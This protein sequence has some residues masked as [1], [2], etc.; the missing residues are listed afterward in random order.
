MQNGWGR[1]L[2]KR[3]ANETI[4]VFTS[5][6][7]LKGVQESTRMDINRTPIPWRESKQEIKW[8]APAVLVGQARS[9]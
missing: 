6:H 8:K 1:Y 2:Q 9:P 5:V 7:E 3:R 4:Q